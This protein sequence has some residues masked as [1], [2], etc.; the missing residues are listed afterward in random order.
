MEEKMGRLRTRN[1]LKIDGYGTCEIVTT[2]KKYAIVHGKILSKSTCPL[3]SAGKIKNSNSVE[4][5]IKAV[6]N[7]EDSDQSY[8]SGLGTLINKAIWKK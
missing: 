2:D 5:I 4:E 3:I 7:Y 8:G 1:I 6:K